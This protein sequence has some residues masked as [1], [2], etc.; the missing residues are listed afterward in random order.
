MATLPQGISPCAD[1][2]RAA[3]GDMESSEIQEIFQLLRG[4]TQEILAREGALS[5]EQAAL[6][7]AD[8]LAKQAEHAAIIEKRNALINV[9]ARARLVAFVRDQFA[10]RPDLGV[11]SFLVGTN[12]ARQGSRLSV[13]AEQKALGDAYIGGMLADLDRADLTAVLAKGDSDQDIADALWRIGK[14]QDVKDLNPQVVEIAKIIQKYQEGA[15]ID[16][17]RAGASIGNLP[18]YIARQSH[19]SEKIGAAGFDKWAEEILPR[20]DA[21]TFR[22]GGGPMTFLKGIYDGLVSGD[23]L[24]SPTGQAPNGF[25][26]PAN[27]AKKLS[28]ERVLHFKDGVAWHE[29]NQLYGT[30]NLREA[31][32]RGLDLSGQNTA[33][34][35]RLGTNP[36]ANLNMA[37]DMIKE[38]VRKGGDPK[39]LANFNTA[40]RGVLDNRFKEVSGQ[41]RI[42]GNATQARVAA[43]VRAWQSLSKLGGALLSSFTDLPV[44]A[45]E[46]RYQGQSFLG[47]LAEMGGGLLKGRGNAEQRQ[48]LSAYGV[49][50]DSMRGEI[51]RRFSADDSVGGKMS[52][53]MSHF[54]RLNGLSWWTDANKASAGL[55]MAHNLAQNKGKGWGSLNPDF[56]RALSL[57]DLDAGKWDLLREMDTRMADGRDYMTPDGIAGISDER[58]GQY[59][60]ERNRPVSAGAIR[61]TRQD[62]ERSL[63]TYVNDRVTYAVL[64]PDARTRSI[65]NQ[66]TQPGTV[67]GDLLRFVTQFKSFPAAY[68]QKTMGRELYGRGYTP[69]ALGNGFRGGRDLIQALRSGNGERLAIAQLMLWTTAFG[70]LSM[71]SKDVTKGREPRPAD[72]P[73]TWLAAMVQGGGLG[74]FGDYLF[75]EASRFGNTALE[76]AAG[77]ALGTAADLINLWARAKEGDDTAASALRLAQNNTPFMNLFYG[78]IV[79]DHLFLYSV[80]EAMNPGSLR[81]TE[82]RIRQQNGQ[83]FLVRP[84]QS[85]QD[86]LG[87]AR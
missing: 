23:H 11:E 66:G 71:A 43:N 22:E 30:G 45:S 42:P 85:Y 83:E 64:E 58:I 25:R 55:M 47:S 75:G 80:Q 86:P 69:T 37:L 24:K 73:K 6:R 60:A 35:R 34:M 61:E 38:D 57:Y 82:E 44:A 79:M 3:A 9:R 51:M 65:M 84:S 56:K 68:M 52:R 15:R 4:R 53:G 40:R 18:G 76:S 10:D 21:T 78:R 63:R 8:E 12:L 41:T 72:D 16:A 81:R 5:S 19:D 27:L 49:Y 14:D 36:E 48:I 54:F 33:L 2:V 1:A 7:A 70:Y 13:A 28:Q 59:L 31:V 74:I 67:P 32:L 46:M 87:I 26:G 17:N 62:L 77:P 39:A 29:Y 50:A 20:L